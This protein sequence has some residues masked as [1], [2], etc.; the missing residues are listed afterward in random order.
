[1]GKRWM[2]ILL[3]LTSVTSARAQVAGQPYLIPAGFEG[4]AAGTLITYGGYNYVTQPDGT[5]LLAAQQP[6]TIQQYTFPYTTTKYF[7]TTPY[8]PLYSPPVYIGGIRRPGPWIG[9]GPWVGPRPPVPW[10][11]RPPGFIPPGRIPGPIFRPR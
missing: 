8:V 9:P 1:M 3:I 5:M 2:F 4:Y 7:Y 10:M 11:G 6:Q